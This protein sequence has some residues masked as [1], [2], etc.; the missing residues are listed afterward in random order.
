MKRFLFYCCVV[1]SICFLFSCEKK[2]D[3]RQVVVY[4]SLDEVYSKPIFETFQKETGI[5]VLA[6]YDS[7]A[8]KTAGLTNRLIAEKDHPQADVIWNSETAR[9]IVLKHKDIL[10]KYISPSAS[11]IPAQCKDAE[12]Y[13]A[14]FAARC[15]VLIYNTNLLKEQDLPKSIF[16]LTGEKWKG[17]VSLAYPIF[18]TTA[19]HVAALYATIGDANAQKYFEALKANGVLLTDGNASSRDKV[20]NGEAAIG[21]TD[22]DDAI[23]AMQEG[24]PVN[25]L[26]PDK[27]GI[28]TLLIPNSVAM[29]KGCPHPEVAK[30]F[31]DFVLSRKVEEMLA[32][33]ESEQIPV[34]ADVVRP[35]HVPAFDKIKVMKVD[36]EKVADFIEPSTQYMQ[37]LFV[38]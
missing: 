12:G 26:W 31:I 25:I 17:K 22:S 29:I 32:K 23:V 38:R 8:T 27:D 19:T 24:R 15:R 1:M 21:F 14:G 6:V 18:G 2:T 10:T 36:Y 30:Q 28:G 13:W 3:Y 33:C 7:E 5:K 37:K 20:A 4:T 34:R 11:D 35:A 16:E 9:T